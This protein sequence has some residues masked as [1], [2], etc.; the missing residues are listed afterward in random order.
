L[1]EPLEVDLEA[2]DAWSPQ[3]TARRLRWSTAPW[4]VVGGWALDLFLRR[5]TR[6]HHDLEIGVPA[7]RFA[8]LRSALGDM[9]LV[10]IG[11]G[12]AWPLTDSTLATHRQTWVREREGAPWRLDIIREPWENDVWIYRRDPTIRLPAADLVRR[13]ADGIPYARPEVIVL[14]KA[15]APSAKDEA[16]F[17][18]VLP[19]LDSGRRAWLREALALAHPEHQWLERLR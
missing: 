3:E 19:E 17:E 18:T 15:R 13:T 1:P 12:R 6:H 4:Y 16:D 9:E 10:A 7:H 11:D 2:W 14:F 8:E 5:Q